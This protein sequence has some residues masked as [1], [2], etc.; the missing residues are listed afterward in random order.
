MEQTVYDPRVTHLE[1]KISYGSLGVVDR[2]VKQIDD[3]AH[4]RINV[5]LINGLTLVRNCLNVQGIKDKEVLGQ[6]KYDVD[7]IKEYVAQY[8][9]VP[10]YLI[11]Y[12]PT[13]IYKTIP[14]HA[15]RNLTDSRKRI[16]YFTNEIVKAEAL[17]ANRLK[18]LSVVDKMQCY[19]LLVGQMFSHRLLGRLI[20]GSGLI[21]PKA[22]MV[23]HCAM[24]YLLLD[25]FTYS[26]L[27][28][29]HTGKVHQPRNLGLK[30]WKEEIPFN[31]TTLKLFGDG[32]FIQPL[33]K[34]RPAALKK[35]GPL[36][37][38]TEREIRQLAIDRLKIIPKQI[39]W[40]L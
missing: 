8:A 16:L 11:F 5:F 4:L 13:N 34:Q 9:K 38:K 29:S 31:A 32:D 25:D 26:R 24:D 17:P 12:F 2:I 20:R 37:L 14:E 7:K 33:V 28:D 6:V 10:S 40:K 36:K 27:I 35:L 19:G 23:S 22:W 3:P 1:E 30:L 15:R 39:D 21:T 18:E